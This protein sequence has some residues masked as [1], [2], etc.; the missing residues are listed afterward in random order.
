M[1]LQLLLLLPQLLAAGIATAD[2]IKALFQ[3]QVP[4][5]TDAEL[6]AVLTLVQAD[7]DRHKALAVAGQQPMVASA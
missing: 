5:L 1:S 3:A 6:N 4:G 7:A 2:Q